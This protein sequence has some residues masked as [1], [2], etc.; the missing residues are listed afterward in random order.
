VPQSDFGALPPTHTLR[1]RQNWEL[2]ID[3]DEEAGILIQSSHKDGSAWPAYHTGAE[4]IERLYGDDHC[5]P[6]TGLLIRAKTDDGKVVEIR[7]SNTDT[8]TVRAKLE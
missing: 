3:G 1:P 6:I 7:V 5:A 2:A 8:T 4:L